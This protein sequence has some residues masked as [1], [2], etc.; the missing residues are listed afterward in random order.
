MN[1]AAVSHAQDPQSRRFLAIGTFG[2]LV[3]SEVIDNLPKVSV[4]E[5]AEIDF[6]S[7]IA[8]YSTSTVLDYPFE[9]AVHHIILLPIETA[10]EHPTFAHNLVFDELAFIKFKAAFA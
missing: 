5:D 9:G 10:A 3:T 2:N 6:H 1:T 4:V 7:T 8:D